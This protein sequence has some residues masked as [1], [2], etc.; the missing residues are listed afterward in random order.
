MTF[1]AMSKVSILKALAG[2]ERGQ[3][4][5]ASTYPHA[6]V[7]NAFV[8]ETRASEWAIVL[9]INLGFRRVQIKCDSLTV[10]KKV[11][12]Y[13]VD[14]SILSPIITDIKYKLGFFMEITFHHARRDANATAH[15]LA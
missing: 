9:A 1:Q 4:I 12:S 11:N 14:C 6:A 8:A 15:V 7:V 13:N 10:I 2:N 3:I 5:G